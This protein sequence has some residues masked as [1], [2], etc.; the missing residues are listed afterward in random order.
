MDMEVMIPTAAVEFNFDSAC[1]TP[2]ISAPSSPQRFGSFFY[3]APTSPTRI[4]TF[5]NNDF[6]G[7]HHQ[8][9]DS[10]SSV[11]FLWEEKPGI[12]KAN[13]A[14]TVV[15]DD[16][17]FAFDFSGQLEVTSSLTTAD[18]LFDGGKIK[19]LKP[20]PGLTTPA[21]SCR[22]PPNNKQMI[23]EALFSPRRRHRKKSGD[24]DSDPFAAA[25]E[26]QT[27]SKD[28]VV[29]DR[30][31]SN[32]PPD[33][34]ERGRERTAGGCRN[35]KSSLGGGRSLSPF[36]VS[37]LLLD[38]EENAK[39]VDDGIDDPPPPPRFSTSSLL[40]SSFVS[41]WYRR[42]WKLKDLLLFRSASDGHAMTKEQLNKYDI[43]K[44]TSISEQQQQQQEDHHQDVKSSSFRSTD[45]CGSL[46]NS[47]SRPARGGGGTVSAHELH[48]RAKRAMAQDLKRKT[49]LPYKPA[50]FFGCLGFNPAAAGAGG[51]SI[52]DISRNFGGSMSREHPPT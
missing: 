32:A 15:D 33:H 14:S 1:T 46:S 51:S 28:C 44:K 7:H 42:K 30:L 26:L 50:G 48:Y 5:Y 11:P 19:P 40:S 13:K 17:D 3:S 4:S 39:E 27:T 8:A 16:D 38:S 6:R 45:S 35:K 34:Q 2:Y 23:K 49:S 9:T 36:R 24:D 43:L 52:H 47:S 31:S 12:P 41:F 20:P 18:E 22:S 37:D 29:Q 25:L 21:Q 10:L